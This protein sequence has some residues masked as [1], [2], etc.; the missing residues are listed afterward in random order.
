[1]NTSHPLGVSHADIL[2]LEILKSTIML[3][4]A[5]ENKIT[6]Q[7]SG[8]LFQLADY[9]FILTCAHCVHCNIPFYLT[10][11]GEPVVP[12]PIEKAMVTIGEKSNVAI[13]DLALIEINQ[14]LVDWLLPFH[15][16]INITEID[17]KPSARRAKYLVAGY[18]V[19]MTYANEKEH[20]V[21]TQSLGYVTGLY[22][23]K[24]HQETEYNPK[25]HI[26][27]SY[28]N[29]CF[30]PE[31]EYS[32]CPPP[33]L[34]GCGIW[35]LTDS[36]TVENWKP[37]DVKLVAIQHRYNAKRNY[38][39]GTWIGLAMKMI[40]DRYEKLRPSLNLIFPSK[41]ETYM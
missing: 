24:L 7:A 5:S 41:R 13:V 33:G 38:I 2:R 22:E 25:A 40:W 35:R 36:E 18:P 9:H 14:E 21:T 34:S 29:K 15:R 20:L 37:E 16:F 19:A 4:T 28:Q 8:I 31:G 11:G 30:G 1:M 23:G 12:R 27:L 17:I 26:V 39:M 6:S 3:C 32:I 10:R